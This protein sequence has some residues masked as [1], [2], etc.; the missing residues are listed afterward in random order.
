MKP[1][2]TQIHGDWG[3]FKL[4][5]LAASRVVVARSRDAWSAVMIA[6]LIEECGQFIGSVIF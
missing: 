2:S 4:L 3:L 6:I 5:W 1:Y